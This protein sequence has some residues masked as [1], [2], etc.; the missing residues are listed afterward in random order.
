MRA[1]HLRDQRPPPFQHRRW[2]MDVCVRRRWAP[3]LL[4]VPGSEIGD[5]ER[6]RRCRLA[7]ELGTAMVPRWVPNVPGPNAVT[8]CPTSTPSTSSPMARHVADTFAADRRRGTARVPDTRHRFGHVAE[9]ES[10]G[11]DANLTSV[12]FGASAV[13]VDRSAGGQLPGSARA[14]RFALVAASAARITGRGCGHAS[15]FDHSVDR[16]LRRPRRP[17]NRQATSARAASGSAVPVYSLRMVT[18]CSNVSTRA[19]PRR[20]VCANVT[21]SPCCNH[22]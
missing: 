22:G 6:G 11:D 12:V 10:G 16:R 17:R 19:M 20:P 3:D 4:C 7:S 21:D 9:V 15:Q 13:Q 1:G 14:V 2:Q 8:R 5:A 18:K